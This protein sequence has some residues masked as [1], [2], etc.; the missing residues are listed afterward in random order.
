MRGQVLGIWFGPRST[1]AEVRDV[2]TGERMATG[3][4]HHREL[5]DHEPDATAWWRALALAI[6]RTGEHTFDALSIAGAHPGLVLVDQAGVALRPMQPWTDAAAAVDHVRHAL[7]MDRWAR[8]AG[9]IPDAGSLIT[10]L[11]WLRR[12]EPE[13]FARVGLALAPHEWLTYRLTG[14]AVTDQGAA[15]ETG[16]WSPHTG[17]WIPEALELLGSAG[18]ASSWVQRLPAVVGPSQRADWLAAPVSE[19]LALQGRPVVGA[20]TGEVMAISLALALRPGQAAVAL[21]DRTAAM[22][23]LDDAITDASGVVRSRAGAEDGHLAVTWESGGA[24]LVDSIAELLDLPLAEFGA[25][26]LATSPVDGVVLVPAIEDGAGAVLTGLDHRM[27]RGV[28]ARAAVDGIACAAANGLDE[29]VGAGARWDDDEPLRLTGPAGAL[30]VHG[31]V[32]A[33]LLGRPVTLI[34]SSMAAAGACVQAAAVV[35]EVAPLEIADAWALG[36]G[37]WVEPS[38]DPAIDDRRAAYAL[39]RSR[40][41]RAWLGGG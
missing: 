1:V 6:N 26:A 12:A 13:T 19:L 31:R 36:D 2:T 21:T 29:L 18:H 5:S 10:R 24:T 22:V 9:M 25:L 15:S 34:P 41:E 28:V 17:N 30:E 4:V 38:D 23:P 27:S 32:L 40:Q 16:A 8:R 20:G 35:H 33:D 11:A 39:E 7:G 14:R 3:V 37:V